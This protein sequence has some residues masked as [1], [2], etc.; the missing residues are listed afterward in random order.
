MSIRG[1]RILLRRGVVSII[2]NDGII[3]SAIHTGDLW[4]QKEEEEEEEEEK[5][6]SNLPDDGEKEEIAVLEEKER[7]RERE[8]VS[9]IGRDRKVETER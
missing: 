5:L 7:E 9:E 3:L 1:F 8:R 2:S 4:I 6:S